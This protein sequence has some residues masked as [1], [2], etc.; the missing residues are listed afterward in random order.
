M[1]A[2]LAEVTFTVEPAG[3][4]VI[5][6]GRTLGQAPLAPQG[7]AAGN[8]TVEISAEGY[9]PQKRELLVTAGVPATLTFKLALIPKTGK[10]HIAAS[11]PQALVRI[12]GKAYGFA[13]VDVELAGGGHQLEISAPRYNVYTSELVVTAGTAR[14]VDATLSRTAHVYEKWYFWTP[15][16]VAAAGLAVGLG[17]GLTS[18]EGPLAGT[19]NPGAG[20]VN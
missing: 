12:D 9:Q 6:D 2:L 17:V 7:I 16:A 20:K 13:H 5:V 4:A 8:H 14:A 18:R 19:L 15:L 11:R 10:V 1:K 3:A